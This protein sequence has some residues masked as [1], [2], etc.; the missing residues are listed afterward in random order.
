MR[1]TGCPQ[2]LGGS[3]VLAT[4]A[5]GLYVS[6][7]GPLLIRSSTRLQGLFFWDLIIYIIEGF[8]FLL[9]GLQA[10]TLIANADIASW[11][12]LVVITALTSVVLIVARFAWVFPA[13]YLPRRLIPAVARSDPSPPWQF[14][15]L[16]AFTG[17]RGVVSLAAALAIPLTLANG[18]PFPDRDLILVITFGVIVVT[19][20]GLGSALPAVIRW[21][22]LAR[23]GSEERLG[24]R[25]AELRARF[26]T[27][28]VAQARLQEIAA[29]RNLPEETTT[30]LSA[31]HD[32]LRRRF[33][34]TPT[35]GA[36]IAMLNDDV[37][38]ELI[39][40]ERQHLHRMLRE[41][42]ITDKSRRR[43]ERDLDLEEVALNTRRASSA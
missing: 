4:V 8:V 38:L 17:V 22:G 35:D 5:A 6:W 7:K 20:I 1:P 32:G 12:E 2:H 3:G 40:A 14:P 18:A 19:L 33:P 31:Y 10:R 41:G 27:L 11:R 23:R 26:E 39:E 43:I 30:L 36:E 28:D 13:T 9:T 16:I 21:L 37:R 34:K 25:E 29:E 24:E 15:F 42:R